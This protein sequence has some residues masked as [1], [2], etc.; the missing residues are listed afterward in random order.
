[1]LARDAARRPDKRPLSLDEL[2]HGPG[3][4]RLFAL[5]RDL[6]LRTLG[7]VAAYAWFTRAGGAKATPFW[8]LMPF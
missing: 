6:L 1:M 2:L 3:L 8:L 5:N 4:R 7:L